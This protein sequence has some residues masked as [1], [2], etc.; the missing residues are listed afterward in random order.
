M[1][2]RQEPEFYALVDED[3]ADEAYLA[4]LSALYD[5][6]VVNSPDRIRIR[7]DVATEGSSLEEVLAV[8]RK[9]LHRGH[10]GTRIPFVTRSG[11]VL[12]D[13]T[14]TIERVRSDGGRSCLLGVEKTDILPQDFDVPEAWYGKLSIPVG[15]AI[16]GHIWQ[17]YMDHIFLAMCAPDA[18]S[19]VKMGVYNVLDKLYGIDLENGIGSIGWQAAVEMAATY[20]G[21][22]EVARDLACSWFDLH[23]HRSADSYVHLSLDEMIM[24]VEK[25]PKGSSV[26]VSSQLDHVAK[27]GL[28][29]SNACTVEFE[30]RTALNCVSPRP[31]YPEDDELSREQVLATLQTPSETLLQALEA[32]AAAPDPEWVEAEKQAL[33]ALARLKESE[34]SPWERLDRYK[35]RCFLE[36]HAPFQVRRLPNG[37]VM[38][39]AYPYGYLWPLWARALDLLGIRPLT[40]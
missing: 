12:Q 3:N 7:H 40:R 25:A 18:H 38:L 35:Q 33:D 23:E 32:A 2:M 15:A 28:D 16:V 27:H 8:K 24:Q 21:N 26:G 1:S 36:A 5:P 13:V 29:E 30:Q 9:D 20:H 19:R 39:N 37:G 17:E 31:R 34:S 4:T 14:V 6:V 22:H 11:Q 10:S